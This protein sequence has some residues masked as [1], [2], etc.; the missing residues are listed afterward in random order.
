MPSGYILD[1]KQLAPSKLYMMY[2]CITIYPG[3]Y[4]QGEG[5]GG[6]RGN[7]KTIT[8]VMHQIAPFEC[9]HCKSSLMSEGDT[10]PRSVASRP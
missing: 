10:L 7:N 4:S 1:M 9:K 2:T 6:V 5:G 8:R 3:P